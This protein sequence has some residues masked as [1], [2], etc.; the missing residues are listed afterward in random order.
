MCVPHGGRERESDGSYRYVVEERDRPCG[1]TRGVSALSLHFQFSDKSV[2]PYLS[3]SSLRLHLSL[4]LFIYIYISICLSYRHTYT[5]SIYIRVLIPIINSCFT[6]FSH[7]DISIYT[8]RTNF[9][10]TSICR[11]HNYCV[12]FSNNI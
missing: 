3:L 6:I 1:G 7:L 9:H 12:F 8:L 2:P 4:A 5:Y 11:T 10:L